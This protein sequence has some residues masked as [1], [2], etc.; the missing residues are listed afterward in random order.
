MRWVAGSLGWMTYRP[1]VWCFKH[2]FIISCKI[3]CKNCFKLFFYKFGPWVVR[4]SN[5]GYYIEDWRILVLIEMLRCHTITLNH[6]VSKSFLYSFILIGVSSCIFLY[7]PFIRDMTSS[8]EISDVKEIFL[9]EKIYK[10]ILKEYSFS[11]LERQ[12]LRVICVTTQ[13]LNP[14]SKDGQESLNSVFSQSSQPV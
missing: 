4:P 9:Q 1:I 14:I 3:L 8:N 6:N 2:F 13:D 7:A 12:W 11:E 5:P 10:S